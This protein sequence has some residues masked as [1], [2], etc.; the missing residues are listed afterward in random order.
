MEIIEGKDLINMKFVKTED[1]LLEEYKPQG[2]FIPNDGNI[3][4]FVNIYG[5]L[6]YNYNT[7]DKEDKY[8]IAH[9]LVFR[10]SEECKDYKWFLEQLDK[11]KTD[12]SK[13]EWEDKDIE[14]YYIFYAYS[15]RK[16]K[17]E[18]NLFWKSQGT[19]Y[20]TK[21]NIEKFID[22]VGEDRI[23]KYMFDV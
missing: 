18:Y 6:V 8:L 1:G 7:N 13:E 3:Y 9:N 23:K 15:K 16:V 11:Y 20:F 2:R 10:T 4:W 12:F 19:V 5:D 17:I 14:K 22:T 21:E